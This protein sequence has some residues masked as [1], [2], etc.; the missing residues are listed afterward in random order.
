[1]PTPQDVLNRCVTDLKAIGALS[2][3]VRDVL[4]AAVRDFA[5]L[6]GTAPAP[7]QQPPLIRPGVE[8]C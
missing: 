2:T 3:K 8:R 5:F 1:M 4:P 7:Q 6:R